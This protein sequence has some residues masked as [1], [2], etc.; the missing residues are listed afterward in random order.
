MRSPTIY[1][2]SSNYIKYFKAYSYASF[3]CKDL[4]VSPSYNFLNF[5]VVSSTIYGK[6]YEGKS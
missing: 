1:K 4:T 2:A 6:F 5:V 3:F